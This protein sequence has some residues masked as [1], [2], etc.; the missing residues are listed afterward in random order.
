MINYPGNAMIEHK[1][2]MVS[3]YFW[4]AFQIPVF[5]VGIYLSTQ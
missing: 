1:D 4:S 2:Q 3:A 5:S